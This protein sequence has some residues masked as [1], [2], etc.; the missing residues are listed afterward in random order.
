MYNLG[1]ETQRFVFKGH[2]NEPSNKCIL[3][4]SVA[5]CPAYTCCVS[6]HGSRVGGV[7]DFKQRWRYAL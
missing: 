5:P 3:S 1:V 2:K 4:P 7:R 6:T